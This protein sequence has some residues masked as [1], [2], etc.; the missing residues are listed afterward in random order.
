MAN[1]VTWFEVVGKDG[2]G[3]Q[4]FYSEA[5]G[6][7]L[8]APA[9]MGY[10]MLMQPEQGIGGGVGQSQDGS[11]QVTFYVEVGDPQAA[12][13]T[14]ESL[15]GKTVVPVTEMEMV[16]FAQ[17]ADPEGNVVGLVKAQQD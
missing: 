14:I 6:W 3:L 5:F 15:G 4:R 8:Q 1:P 11:G 2:A 13:E 10:G 7:Q 17:F 12:L 9:N 16:T